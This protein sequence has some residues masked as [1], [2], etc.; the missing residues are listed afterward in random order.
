M[1]ITGD[2]KEL[3]WMFLDTE[4]FWSADYSIAGSDPPTY[5]LDPRFRAICLG[6]AFGDDPPRLIEDDNIPAF[7]ENLKALQR[8]QRIAFVSHNALFDACILAWKYGW[9]PDLVVCTL[10]M[11]RSLLS[12]RLG[13]VSLASV[14]S[15]LGRTKG[16]MV[17]ACRGMAKED[18][19]ANGLWDEYAAYCLNDVEICR[20]A[21]NHMLPRMPPSEFILQDIILRCAIEPRFIADVPL[22]HEHLEDVKWNKAK[23]FAKA[24]FA[25]LQ[26]K[27]ELMSNDRFAEL[28]IR[29]GANPP[30]RISKATGLSTWSLNRQTPEFMQLL[31]HDDPKVVALV[32]ARL[33]WKSTIEETRA[34]RMLD[35]AQLTFDGKPE[36]VMP[37][38]LKMGAAITHRLGGDWCL[39]GTTEVV[40]YDGSSVIT[41]RIVDVDDQ[42]LVWD[43][44]EFVAHEG[45]VYSGKQAVIEYDGIVGTP[46]HTV[47]TET[48]RQLTLASAATLGS[49]LCIPDPPARHDIKRAARL[50]ADRPHAAGPLPVRLRQ[51]S[52]GS[53]GRRPASQQVQKLRPV[54]AHAVPQG[55][56]CVDQK[57]A[58]D[59]AYPDEAS[60]PSASADHERSATALLQSPFDGL[61][62]LRR[63]GNT[64][65]LCRRTR[66]GGMDIRSHRLTANVQTYDRPHQQRRPLRTGQPSLGDAQR[67]DA[68][69][70]L[71]DVYD[72]LNCG[73]RHR[74]VANGR[75]VHNSMNPQNWGRT[76]PIRRAMTAPEG[77]KVVV[78]D[79]AQIEARL[80]AWFCGQQDLVDQFARGEDVYASF[81]S[82]IFHCSVTKET[83]P[84][85]RFTG[86][87]GILQCGYQ[88]GWEK[89]QSTVWLQSYDQL[90]AAIDLSDEEAQ[91]IVSG[92]RNRY[93]AISG[94]WRRLG[95]IIPR[96]SRD[97]ARFGI[98]PVTFDGN[99]V[100]GPGGL[101]IIYE[102]LQARGDIDEW[103]YLQRGKLYKLY[104]G[105][106]LEHIVQFLA[107]IDTMDV[108]VRLKPR[109]ARFNSR[110]T[111]TSHDE[112]VYIVE[113]KFVPDAMTVLREEMTRVPDWAPGLPLAVDIGV[114]QSYGDAK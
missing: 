12:H 68:Q 67:A 2:G 13:S 96:M 111:H 54:V 32:E 55:E 69:P 70:S 29:R 38:P 52:N 3:M 4:T 104:G 19:K 103:T 106:L 56:A 77:H 97:N 100:T 112:I 83:E 23:L 30:R 87:T 88:C 101:Q 22:L 39:L 62:E 34:Q 57:P 89:F 1:S 59:H 28:L 47:Y 40:C 33:A 10:S 6:F 95:N 114:G 110:L 17:H 20:A 60:P 44:E 81:A 90:D 64:V 98:G 21:F 49:K 35:I 84:A 58:E 5:I 71:M 94:M 27:T 92:Y 50:W 79:K 80:N 7:I 66:S 109:M 76:S 73:P 9:L 74:F 36:H 78:A 53:I 46:E 25:G 63:Q 82:E 14:A 105:K 43:G 61:P 37:I 102:G 16:D 42:D 26:D 45:V 99:V 72:I 8:T 24:M 15:Y 93:A 86:K 75:L 108:I 65:Q 31:E 107:R 91:H 51:D 48:G 113:D 41:K 85:K 18:I 11:A